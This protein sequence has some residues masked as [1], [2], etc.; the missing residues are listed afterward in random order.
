MDKEIIKN[1]IEF[2]NNKNVQKNLFENKTFCGIPLIT[3]YSK[4]LNAMLD[5]A[6]PVDTE[7]SLYEQLRRHSG[8]NVIFKNDNDMKNYVKELEEALAFKDKY[9]GVAKCQ[10]KEEEVERLRKVIFN[11]AIMMLSNLI[12][13]AKAHNQNSL[14]MSL[15]E[16]KDL[17]G[18]IKR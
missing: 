17:L 14:R 12:A 18:E 8:K 10:E 9:K 2:F 5:E 4:G 15:Q 13:Q 1:A 6:E 3:I 16:V 7:F 11:Q